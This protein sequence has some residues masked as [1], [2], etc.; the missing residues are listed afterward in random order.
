MIDWLGEEIFFFSFSSFSFE[1][2]SS[3]MIT[4]LFDIRILEL[5]IIKIRPIFRSKRKT[6]SYITLS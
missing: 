6:T 5:G 1:E 4:I 3:P 2:F